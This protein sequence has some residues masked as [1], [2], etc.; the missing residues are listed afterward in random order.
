[1]AESVF[2]IN[3]SCKQLQIVT[4]TVKDKKCRHNPMQT[5]IWTSP[6]QAFQ[7]KAFFFSF[8]NYFKF[9]FQIRS[10]NWNLK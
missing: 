6:T 10:V 8:K 7:C 9:Y 5:R 4:D 3:L 2:S 1:M